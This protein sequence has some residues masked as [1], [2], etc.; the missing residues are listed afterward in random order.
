MIRL[1]RITDYGIVLMADLAS[2]SLDRAHNA[3]DLAAETQL[4]APVVSKILKALA[5]D[6]SGGFVYSD[7]AGAL[8]GCNTPQQCGRMGL[9]P[10]AADR[11]VRAAL[12]RR[13][14]ALVE[15]LLS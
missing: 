7:R 11:H 2:R 3:R 10:S 14:E 4:P 6:G 12:W 9:L 5:R 1:S 13:S 8:S 15:P